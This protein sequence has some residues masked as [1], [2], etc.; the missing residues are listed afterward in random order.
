MRRASMRSEED[1]ILQS[2]DERSASIG[3]GG[4]PRRFGFGVVRSLEKRLDVTT[5]DRFC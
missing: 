5:P 1:P 2:R 4:R 3:A